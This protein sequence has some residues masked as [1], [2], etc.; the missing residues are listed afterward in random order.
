[1]KVDNIPQQLRD[2]AQ[3]VTW[4]SESGNKVPYTVQGFRASK[5]NPAHWCTFDEAVAD[6]R[7]TGIGFCFTPDD[8]FVGVD[9]D[10]CRNPETGEIEQWARNVITTIGSYAEVSPSRT[11]VKI[12]AIGASPWESGRNLDLD[13]P[14]KYGKRPGIEIYD[15]AAYFCITLK[16]LQGLAELREVTQATL[17]TLVEQLPLK[18]QAE[19]QRPTSP[20]ASSSDPAVVERARRYV[21]TMPG[22]IAGQRGHDQT[23]RVACVLV[24]G[25]C[26]SESDAFAVLSEYNDRCDPPWS[27]KDLQHKIRSAM[28]E[29]GERGYLRDARED[30]W[31]S[32]VVPEYPET[33]QESKKR[34]EQKSITIKPV[35]QSVQER[36]DSLANDATR[37]K[38]STGLTMLDDRL[39]GGLS[40]ESLVV[41]GARN[42]HGKSFF[43]AQLL[44]EL[45]RQGLAGLIVSDEMAEA[46]LADRA[47]LYASEIPASEWIG[48]EDEL[49][50]DAEQ[51]FNKRAGLYAIFQPQGIGKVL[52]AIRQAHE[53]HGVQ[54]VVVDYLQRL[55]GPGRTETE[56]CSNATTA[57][58]RLS[59]ELGIITIALAQVGRE[60]EKQTRNRTQGKAST[61]LSMEDFIPGKSDLKQSGRIEEEADVVLMGF[62]CKSAIP[63]HPYEHDYLLRC[64]KNRNGKLDTRP[65]YCN[66]IGARA[67]FKDRTTTRFDTDEPQ[68]YSE[69]DDFNQGF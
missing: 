56:I 44:Y 15:H 5:T 51:H 32:T 3:W 41:V 63:T 2:V 37:T 40:L 61:Q 35:R 11:G 13:F 48:R 53:Q 62:H 68:R 14:D 18:R 30:D 29:P 52:A 6:T 42:G 59:R 67:M 46:M 60:F 54:A 20:P 9:L 8:P 33:K 49:R 39:Q 64:V 36:I 7:K 17:R 12:I 22:A 58:G 25:F 4:R 21:A 16:R 45:A 38:Y 10:G 19:P 26:L 23:F 65:V 1:M 31:P 28:K 27:A 66:F 55:T 24:L 47:L 43:G 34:D 57:L 69:F 50:A